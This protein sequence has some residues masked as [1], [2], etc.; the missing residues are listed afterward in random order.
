MNI[1]HSIVLQVVL[2][3]KTAPQSVVQETNNLHLNVPIDALWF[4]TDCLFVSRLYTA[5]YNLIFSLLALTCWWTFRIK[6]RHNS[7]S[8]SNFNH[9]LCASSLKAKAWKFPQTYIGHKQ[10]TM[11]P[12]AQEIYL[13]DSKKTAEV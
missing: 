1:S 5:T 6:S 11:S 12:L 2:N 8:L 13:S 7:C 4:V 9:N 10:I 3:Y